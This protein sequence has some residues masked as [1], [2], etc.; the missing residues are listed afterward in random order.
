[1][2]ETRAVEAGPL[3]PPLPDRIMELMPPPAQPRRPEQAVPDTPDLFIAKIL[4]AVGEA[5]DAGQQANH[6]I[7]N[8][9]RI[10]DLFHQVHQAATFGVNRH[11]R[12]MGTAKRRDK[13]VVRRESLREDRR[14]AAAETQGIDVPRKAGIGDRAEL[15][16][17][18]AVV[19]QP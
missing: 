4:Q 19:L 13:G 16:Q 14:E 2:T 9:L 1:M 7:A 6:R 12:F 15:H 11:L 3:W 10:L 17:F 18:G 5:A 8:L